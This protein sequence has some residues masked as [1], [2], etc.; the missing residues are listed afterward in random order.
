MQTAYITHSDC[1]RHEMLA[2]HPE[3]PER[4]GAIEDRLLASGLMDF[5]RHY[6]APKAE[7]EQLCAVHDAEY[8]D[9]VFEAAPAQGEDLVPLDPDTWMNAYTLDAA[10]RAAGALVKAT[11]LVL[12]GEVKR[13]FCGVRPPGHHAEHDAAMGFCFF[14]NVGVGAAHALNAHGLERVA[15]VDFDVHHGN[16]TEDVFDAEPRVLVCSAYQHPFY[17]YAGRDTVPGH[18]INV[19]LP[20]GTDG[21][22]YRA[23]VTEHWLPAL[24]AFKPQLIYVSAGFDAHLEDD[25]AHLRLVESDYAWITSRLLEVADKHAGGRLISTLEGGYNLSALGRSAAAHIKVLMGL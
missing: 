16:G 22:A 21:T 18:L 15:V 25:M 14:N 9:T 17:P 8:V 10:L 24:D 12:S 23:A 3:C 20:A 7:R 11:D 2:G 13:A 5:L 4:L 1:S 6:D 19:P